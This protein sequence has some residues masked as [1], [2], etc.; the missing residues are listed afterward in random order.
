MG[1]TAT[2]RKGNL[3][4]ECGNPHW[5]KSSTYQLS[6]ATPFRGWA[7]EFLR[8]TGKY[9][10]AVD[11]GDD[12]MA[13]D[14]GLASLVKYDHSFP[15]LAKDTE[16]R[17]LAIQAYEIYPG[18]TPTSAL[19]D[20]QVAVV[21]DLRR[22]LPSATLQRQMNAVSQSLQVLSKQRSNVVATATKS[23]GG[24]TYD[25]DAL[26]TY[27]R[28][29]DAVAQDRA[30][31]SDDL[32]SA[33]NLSRRASARLHEIHSQAVALFDREYLRLVDL[34]LSPLR[35]TDPRLRE[36]LGIHWNMSRPKTKDK[37]K[38]EPNEA[39]WD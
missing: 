24:R 29:A 12:R 28:F 19:E 37:P 20:G 32:A 22:G 27:L 5:E 14:F 9:R 10:A 11:A 6:K 1:R 34:D 35:R 13:G 15:T 8:R 39:S 26:L 2:W 3:A 4:W 18:T 36:I 23:H 21:F 25:P 16:P 7:W 17:W 33:L 38:K 30:I 31:S